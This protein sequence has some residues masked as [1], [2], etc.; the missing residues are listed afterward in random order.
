LII[1]HQQYHDEHQ[2]GPHPEQ[3]LKPVEAHELGKAEVAQRVGGGLGRVGG[4]VHGHPAQAHQQHVDEHGGPVDAARRANGRRHRL[5][6]W[7][8]W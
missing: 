4:R 1:N 8:G 3:L 7:R 2:R 6:A 5:S